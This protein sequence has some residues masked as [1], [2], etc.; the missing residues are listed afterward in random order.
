MDDHDRSQADRANVHLG[1]AGWSAR[2]HRRCRP[3]RHRARRRRGLDARRQLDPAT[4]RDVPDRPHVRGSC[5]SAPRR[6][7][8]RRPVA[9]RCP[10]AHLPPSRRSG[11]LDVVRRR[12]AGR[13]LDRLQRRSGGRQQQVRGAVPRQ[14]HHAAHRP[15][16]RSGIAGHHHP[17]RPCPRH[18][19]APRTGVRLV[20]ADRCRRD[21]ARPPGGHGRFDLHL[22]RLPE[23]PLRLRRKSVASTSGSGSGSPS[24]PPSSTPSSRSGS[25][26]K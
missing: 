24:R 18:E 5:P 3:A 16:C 20:G 23:R 15:R 17:H 8:R 1:V 10:I 26:W 13:H 12:S 2:R 7:D 25:Q 4:V 22:R 21:V 14:S 11:I 9:T 6:R 19:H